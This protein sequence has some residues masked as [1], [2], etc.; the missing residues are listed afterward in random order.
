MNDEDKIKLANWNLMS[1][2]LTAFPVLYM[3]NANYYTSPTTQRVL[4]ALDPMRSAVIDYDK[5]LFAA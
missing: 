4:N 1:I 3:M 2:V 5:R